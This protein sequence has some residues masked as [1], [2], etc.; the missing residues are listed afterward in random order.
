MSSSSGEDVQWEVARSVSAVSS[1][2]ELEPTDLKHD[3]VPH[4]LD[5]VKKW[6]PPTLLPGTRSSYPLISDVDLFYDKHVSKKLAL[7][8]IKT[9]PSILH[10]ICQLWPSRLSEIGHK[11]PGYADDDGLQE[12]L[13]FTRSPII[14]T[15]QSLCHY[16]QEATAALAEVV[17]S[18]LL[19]PGL[20][21]WY[22]LFSWD[23]EASAHNQSMQDG[24]GLK[25]L[26]ENQLRSFTR[27]HL[28]ANLNADELETLTA[29]RRSDAILGTWIV[30]PV[31]EESDRILREMKPGRFKTEILPSKGYNPAT[32][33]TK[34]LHDADIFPWL[35]KASVAI[36]EPITQGPKRSTRLQAKQK[37]RAPLES[38]PSKAFPPGPKAPTITV[39][40]M[41]KYNSYFR[42]AGS[43]NTVLQRVSRLLSA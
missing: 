16:Y 33:H 8:R 15:S 26:P 11:L 5:A 39:P 19:H 23:G 7:V 29:F 2:S 13:T 35:K 27:E 28:L 17:S 12:P 1:A 25:V 40:N 22:S 18:V 21:G 36:S 20:E 4:I 34:T 42:E 30:L 3:V 6:N 9:A 43:A 41:K 10:D 24:Y 37:Q 38:K 14:S 31:G 32:A